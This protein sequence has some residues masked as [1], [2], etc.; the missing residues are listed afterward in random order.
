M[1]KN[2]GISNQKLNSDR[3][4][5]FKAQLYHP[6]NPPPRGCDC[7]GPTGCES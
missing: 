2:L 6:D 1:P 3:H 7:Y 5:V 4:R